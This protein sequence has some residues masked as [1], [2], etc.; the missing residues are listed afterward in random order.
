[1]KKA[2]EFA[3]IYRYAL[4]F[5]GIAAASGLFALP[6]GAA[7]QDPDLSGQSISDAV[8]DELTKDP[9]VPAGTLRIETTN[10]IVTLEGEVS[11]ILAKERAARIARIVK[12][13]KGVINRINVD[14]H[15]GLSDSQIR[16]DLQAALATNPATEAFE[17]DVEV[18]DGKVTLTGDDVDSWQERKL[19]TKVAKGV[20]GVT[21]VENRIEIDYE[22]DR[23]DHEIKAEIKKSLRW[24][25]LVDQAMIDVAVDNGKVTLSGTVGSAAERIE[26]SFDAWVAGVTYVN[27]SKLEV[28]K[29]ARDEELRG[30]KFEI[31][32]DEQVKDAIQHVFT[33]DP[34]V[35][36]SQIEVEIN[37]GVVT[38]R[39]TVDNLNAKRVAA[40]DA[41]NTVGVAD[42]IN[43][44]KV[45]PAE[46]ID[47]EELAKRIKEAIERNPFLDR[48]EITV[49][50]VDGIA[51]LYGDVDSYYEKAEADEV[52]SQVSGVIN[53]KNNLKV[54]DKHAPYVYNPY[55][56]DGGLFDYNWYNY[57]P[58]ETLMRSDAKIKSEVMDEMWWSPFVDATEL[59]ISINGGV[60]TLTGKVD[61]WVEYNAAEK[62]AMEVP[63][64]RRV[65]N[66]LRVE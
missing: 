5:F 40:M 30:N 66:H 3:G 8:E 55:V 65:V 20:K 23:P 7:P 18:N 63:G 35:N 61:S 9:A 32:S 49:S 28:K 48:H 43:R 37:N 57:E 25:V 10:G 1:M 26:A 13:V 11:N 56:D 42:V 21:K 52:T 59:D 41:H 19:I 24:D 15:F 27:D 14:P 29:W 38:L 4:I 64:V 36:S 46:E 50:V 17:V 22:T 2:R 12:G 58:Y 45:S 54:A 39:G 53:V 6:A 34:R 60:V 44:I 31:K 47:E 33:Y 62:N 16:N 51:Y